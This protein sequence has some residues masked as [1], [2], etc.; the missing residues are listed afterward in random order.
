MTLPQTDGEGLDLALVDPAGEVTRV[1]EFDADRGSRAPS[2]H[3]TVRLVRP[4]ALPGTQ[5]ASQVTRIGVDGVTSTVTLEDRPERSPH[6][7]RGHHVARVRGR[8]HLYSRPTRSRDGTATWHHAVVGSAPTRRVEHVDRASAQPAGST[9]RRDVRL[10]AAA[11]PMQRGAD[12][13]MY[14]PRGGVLHDRLAAGPGE[15]GCPLRAGAARQQE[16]GTAR[17]GMGGG[18]VW[19]RH[20]AG[21]NTTGGVA[22]VDRLFAPRSVAANRGP[23]GACTG[24]GRSIPGPGPARSDRVSGR[25]RRAPP[26]PRPGR[27]RVIRRGRT[28]VDGAIAWRVRRAQVPAGRYYLRAARVALDDNLTTCLGDVS[29]VRRARAKR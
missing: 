7:G 14:F 6:Q 18:Y 15:P 25:R 1:A 28:G 27:D 23:V 19:L 24:Q 5:I 10:G 2:V 17:A 11:G 3:R 16:S 29:P 13:R 21:T 26:R 12:G 8:R 4:R 9:F 22:A 20:R